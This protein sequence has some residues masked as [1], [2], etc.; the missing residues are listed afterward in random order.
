[1]FMVELTPLRR[2]EPPR[3]AKNILSRINEIASING[4][5]SELRALDTINRSVQK[6]AIRM[7]LVSMPEQPAAALEAEASTKR[8]VGRVLFEMLRQDGR[9]ACEAW[10]EET[11]RLLGKRSSMDIGARYLRPYAAAAHAHQEVE[12]ARA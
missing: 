7:H 5:I 11:G 2:F 12:V 4:L 3:S 9:C 6:A 10:L 1:M 8:T